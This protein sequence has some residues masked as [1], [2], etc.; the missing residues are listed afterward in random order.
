MKAS[1]LTKECRIVKTK[2][3]WSK[4]SVEWIEGDTAYVSV[5]FTWNCR[6]H[7]RGARR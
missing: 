6:K 1:V 2:S 5:P 4:H 3:V 7:F